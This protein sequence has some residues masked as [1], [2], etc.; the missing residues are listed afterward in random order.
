MWWR[1]RCRRRICRLDLARRRGVGLVD[2]I[3]LLRQV[4]LVRSICLG[5]G[6]L[7]LLGTT[8]WRWRLRSGMIQLRVGIVVP[9][10]VI[11][12]TL[13]GEVGIPVSRGNIWLI[14]VGEIGRLQW[15]ECL[16]TVASLLQLILSGIVRSMSGHPRL[17]LMLVTPQRRMLRVCSEGYGR[18]SMVICRL[19]SIHWRACSCWSSIRRVSL[20]PS[21]LCLISIQVSLVVSR[22]E[23]WGALERT[24]GV[25]R[26]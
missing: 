14:R 25:V 4:V 3:L 9:I 5:T 11:H 23:T 12:R 21:G 18:G 24:R 13:A 1:G 26:V 6:I 7:R 20:R 15:D 22:I 17:V 8:R 2:R 10:T 19:C 16:W